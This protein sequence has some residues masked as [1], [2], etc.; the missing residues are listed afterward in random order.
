MGGALKLTLYCPV[1]LVR[2]FSLK[3][4]Y[5]GRAGEHGGK[6]AKEIRR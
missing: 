4:K 1:D 2:R 5:H 6:D 3:N